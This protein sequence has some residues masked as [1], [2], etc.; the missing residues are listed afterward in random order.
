M[1]EAED[2]FTENEDASSIS[3]EPLVAGTHFRS[4][5]QEMK[6]FH[7]QESANSPPEH[8]DLLVYV[9]LQRLIM[10]C[11]IYFLCQSFVV[12]LYHKQVL[13][14][15][16]C[17]LFVE[18]LSSRNGL[19]HGERTRMRRVVAL[20]E[21]ASSE[22]FRSVEILLLNSTRKPCS[23]PSGSTKRTGLC[24]MCGHSCFSRGGD[25]PFPLRLMKSRGHVT[26]GLKCMPC[27]WQKN[28]AGRVR[29]EWPKWSSWE[30]AL[31]QGLGK[32]W[33]L[34]QKRG[35]ASPL[36]VLPSGQ[37]SAATQ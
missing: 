28:R 2:C 35:N 19:A 9:S 11:R 17:A 24:S 14:R 32:E 30:R 26:Y 10:C 15:N 33:I 20:L 8:Q 5:K 12:E 7:C 13:S 4:E 6:E 29:Q 31:Q 23:N 16:D 27:L 21:S 1:L 22:D 18:V 34:A 36:D 25:S 37:T 3:E